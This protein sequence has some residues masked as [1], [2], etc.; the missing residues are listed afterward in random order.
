MAWHVANKYPTSF[1]RSMSWREI[2]FANFHKFQEKK[3]TNADNDDDDD[4]GD[5]I[6][7]RLFHSPL[8][9]E[10]FLMKPPSFQSL[11]KISIVEVDHLGNDN[12]RF[13]FPTSICIVHKFPTKCIHNYTMKLLLICSKLNR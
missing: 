11:D 13:I 6:E 9:H 4:N 1:D 12:L 5:V 3:R 7:M 2:N 8:E 10:I